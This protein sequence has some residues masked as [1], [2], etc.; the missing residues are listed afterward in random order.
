MRPTVDLIAQ[1]TDSDCGICSIAMATGRTY[2]E[3]MQAAGAEFDPEKG[4]RN[5]Q[6]VLKALGLSSSANGDF[7]CLYSGILTGSFFRNLA[8]G[9]RALVSAPS[10]NIPGGSHMLYVDAA[11]TVFDPCLRQR[12]EHFHQLEPTELTLFRE[13]G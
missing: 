6:A 11:G 9:R 13:I 10:L 12:Y 2:E 7:I 4:L 8:W 1:R 5:E 3:V